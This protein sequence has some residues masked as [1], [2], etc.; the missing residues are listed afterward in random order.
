MGDSFRAIVIEDVEGKQKAA[1]RD[2]TL[3]DL[4]DHDVL[5][6][7]AWSTLNYKDGMAVSGKRI[8]RSLPMV[9]GID[10]AGTVAES[11]SPDW[12]PG[13]KVLVNGYGLSERH[14]GGY[15]Q[16]QRLKAEW[17]VPLPSAFDMQQAMAIGTAGYTAMLSVMA[18]EDAGLTRDAAGDREILVTGAAG[19]VGS[20]AVALLATLGYRVT[21]ATGRPETHD[22]LRGLGASGFVAREDLAG[23][24]KPLEGERWAAVVDSVGSKTLAS[25]L[26]Q[27]AYGGAVAACGLAGGVDLPTTVMPFILRGVKLLG[28]D[29]VMAPMALRRRAWDRLAKDLDKDKLAAIGAEVAPLTAVP[30]LAGKILKGQVRGRVVIDVNAT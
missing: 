27:T 2:L 29:S 16:R 9:G 18:L 20:V 30:D 11:R 7:V 22:Y 6:D 26:A 15:A 25:A 14:W 5:V 24:A 4:P 10:L 19:G 13:D 1:L 12:K 23:D 8:A 17:L 28:I 21:A 3:A